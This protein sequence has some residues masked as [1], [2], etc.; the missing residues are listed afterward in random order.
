MVLPR[1][2]RMQFV[3]I[4]RKDTLA[5]AK[6]ASS[7]DL[8]PGH[9]QVA[10]A[11]LQQSAQPITIA[12]PPQ[13]ASRPK[14]DTSVVAY[15]VMWTIRLLRTSRAEF[16]LWIT[17]AVTRGSTIVRSMRSVSLYLQIID[18]NAFKDLSTSRQIQTCLEECANQL[19]LRHHQRNI[20][21]KILH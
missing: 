2:V 15:L 5:N 19:S 13:L 6:R 18:A 12:V 1:A 7:I 14:A 21:A 16:A 20:R 4:W 8:H 17:N 9:S 3:A 11:V 10:Y